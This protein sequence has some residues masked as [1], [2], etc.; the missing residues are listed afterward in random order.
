MAKELTLRREPFGNPAERNALVAHNKGDNIHIKRFILSRQFV[1]MCAGHLGHPT[2]R[3]QRAP[4]VGLT[5]GAKLSLRR[6]GRCHDW[7]AQKPQPAELTALIN[8]AN[9]LHA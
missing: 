3:R 2:L 1:L 7:E 6:I 5:L 9:W 8:A 4:L